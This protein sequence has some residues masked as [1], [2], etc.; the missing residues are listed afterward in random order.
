MLSNKI[1]AK[2]AARNLRIRQRSRRK[3]IEYLRRSP[4]T[5]KKSR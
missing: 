3:G 5:V 1:T 2:A 4:E